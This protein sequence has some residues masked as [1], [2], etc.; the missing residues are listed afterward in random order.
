MPEL[1]AGQNGVSA[2]ACKQLNTQN[3]Q[4]DDKKT[5]KITFIIYR[6]YK[7]DLQI[8]EC[9]YCNIATVKKEKKFQNSLLILSDKD[10]KPRQ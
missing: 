7:S 4:G 5:W 9:K 10:Y 3:T 8:S 6:S 1:F 2:Q